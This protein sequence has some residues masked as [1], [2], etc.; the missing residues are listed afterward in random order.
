MN[1]PSTFGN[2]TALNC[3]YFTNVIKNSTLYYS[4]YTCNF[5]YSGYSYYFGNSYVLDQCITIPNCQTSFKLNG[6]KMSNPN[7]YYDIMNLP[8]PLD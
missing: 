1:F 2:I 4:C 8:Y 5:G 3:K 6:L 7:F